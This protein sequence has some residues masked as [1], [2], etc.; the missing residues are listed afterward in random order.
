MRIAVPQKQGKELRGLKPIDNRQRA[1]MRKY[2][3]IMERAQLTCAMRIYQIL[4]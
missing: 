4:I 1:A 3:S 2:Q